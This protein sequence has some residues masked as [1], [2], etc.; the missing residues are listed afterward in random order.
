MKK[1]YFLLAAFLL[2]SILSLNAQAVK[3]SALTFKNAPVLFKKEG[4]MFQQIIAN[5][6]SDKSVEI[7]FSIAGKKIL[8]SA[9]TKGRNRLLLTV[10]AVSSAK[11]IIISVKGDRDFAGSYP[12]TIMPVKKWE[13]Y[14]VQHSHTDIGYTRPQSEILAEHMRYID[15]ALD[16]CD[17]T[18]QLPD[19]AKFRWS[20]ESA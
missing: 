1:N 18:D 12:L 2:A 15:Y 17:Q 4:K 7:V 11:K 8:K 9:I 10:P 20:C 5:I 14:F 3:T 19:D 6:N 13:I 16:Y